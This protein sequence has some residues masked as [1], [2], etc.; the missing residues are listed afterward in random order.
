MGKL[1]DCLKNLYI[2][3]KELV[4]YVFFGGLTTVVSFGTHFG[5]ELLF[6][7]N[8]N[9]A[10]I[11]SW[12]CA[13]TFAFITNKKWV[14]NSKTKTFRAFAK[15]FI[16]FYSARLFSLG[17]EYIIILIFV[18]NLHFNEFLFKILA[19]VVVLILN[20]ILSKLIVF[21]KKNK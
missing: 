19:N 18:T 4:L 11:I 10:V 5:S 9:T 16:A 13:V 8:S 2:K 20:F 7:V 21:T 14:F 15:E 3:Y 6:H 1:I 12:V 17:V